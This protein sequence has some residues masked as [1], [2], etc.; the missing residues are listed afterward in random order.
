LRHGIT[1]FL[2]LDRLHRR[3][4]AVGIEC[5]RDRRRSGQRNRF[6][7]EFATDIGD[8]CTF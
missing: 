7:V 6:V 2:A 8:A 1:D 5:R 3:S 4:D